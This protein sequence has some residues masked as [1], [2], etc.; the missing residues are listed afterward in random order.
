MKEKRKIVLWAEF[1]ILNL[2]FYGVFCVE[3]FAADTY[4]TEICGWEEVFKIY[5]KNGRWIMAC[6]CKICQ[7]FN[8]SFTVEKTTSW[9]LA[10]VFLSLAE[11]MLHEILRKRIGEEISSIRSV[12]VFLASFMMISNIFILEYFIF[13]EYTGAICIGIFFNV[14]EVKL[15]LQ[16]LEK[17]KLKDFIFGLLC[18]ILGIMGHQ[19]AFGI[20]A[21]LLILLAKGTFADIKSFI[22]NSMIIGTAYLIP[23]LTNTVQT[24]LA[25]SM[26]VAGSLNLLEATREAGQ[27]TLDLLISTANFMPKGIYLLMCGIAG[28]VVLGFILVTHRVK[29]LLHVAYVLLV[30]ILAVLAPFLMTDPKYISVVPRTVYVMGAGFPVILILLLL[31]GKLQERLLQGT[32][33]YTGIFLSI[34]YFNTCQVLTSHYVS[35]GI[36]YYDVNYIEQHVWIYENETGNRI[37]KIKIYTDE[38]PLGIYYNLTGYGAVNERVLSNTWAAAKVYEVF[39][40][41]E[42]TVE[43]PDIAVYEQYFKGKN[44]SYLNNEQIILIGD[45]LHLC[46]Y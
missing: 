44:W 41:R 23:A 42:L 46:L 18:G 31:Q 39:T 3:H 15:V 6:M 38:N 14:L 1:A 10:I 4:F 30:F 16:F 37:S 9:I 33:I 35:N 11:M 32:L 19:G 34:Q 5:W 7:V 17:G 21:V 12:L 24:K 29:E 13:A 2:C 8:I 43:E 26:R 25:G 36:D 27:Q 45:T 22:K 28:M 20:T 40:G